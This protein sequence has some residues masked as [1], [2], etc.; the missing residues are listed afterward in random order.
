MDTAIKVAEVAA[1]A[2]S[3]V[4]VP[5]LL[6]T[7]GAIAELGAVADVGISALGLEGLGDSFMAFAEDSSLQS[8]FNAAKNVSK[9]AGRVTGLYKGTKM[10]GKE[11]MK[12][13]REVEGWF[14]HEHGKP[15]RGVTHADIH[16]TV[17]DMNFKRQKISHEKDSSKVQTHEQ[18]YDKSDVVNAQGSDAKTIVTKNVVTTNTESAS[19]YSTS[20]VPAKP[21]MLP[22][23]PPIEVVKPPWTFKP[24]P[25]PPPFQHVGQPRGEK[26]KRRSNVIPN[27]INAI[28]EQYASMSVLTQR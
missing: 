8:A 19:V 20:D 9:V 22:R 16:A 3:F 26:R 7:Y 6:L 28:E 21:I 5:E 15:I 12:G 13:V 24:P 17:G 2:A 4:L 1:V 10:V 18:N 27:V 25:P 14:S 23:I 11:V